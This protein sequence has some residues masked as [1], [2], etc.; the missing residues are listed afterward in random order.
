MAPRLFPGRAKFS[1][2]VAGLAV[3]LSGCAG[4]TAT[5]TLP[6]DTTPPTGP[7]ELTAASHQKITETVA[8]HKGKVVVVDVWSTTCIPC[9][10]EFPHLV[11][12][13]K[14]HGADKLACLSVSTDPAVAPRLVPATLGTQAGVIGAAALAATAFAQGG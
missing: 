1:L 13:H 11:A 10:K 9:M 2:A 6:G 12:L 4:T 3:L 14:Q 7:V 8:A 5:S